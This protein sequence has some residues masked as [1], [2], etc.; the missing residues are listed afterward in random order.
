LAIA[1][2]ENGDIVVVGFFE[3]TVDFG[4]G[5]LV[6]ASGL[7][8]IFLAKFSGADGSHLWSSAFGIGAGKAVAVDSR[9]NVVVSGF[10]QGTVDFGD[11]E[12][13]SAG[14][15]DIFV[16]K[17]YGSDGSHLWSNRY[18]STGADQGVAIA[19]DR[20]GNVVVTGIFAG[21]VDFGGGELT[22]VGNQDIFVLK[23][24]GPRLRRAQLVSE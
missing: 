3:G 10:F 4:G 24:L 11:G 13:T 21:T 18:G 20:N 1:V 7:N 6:G 8:N 23:L 9:G 5:S 15:T 16:A 19:A 17:Y 12:L 14:D 22:S 2:D